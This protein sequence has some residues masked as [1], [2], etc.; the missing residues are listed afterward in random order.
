M[1]GSLG[2]IDSSIP[3]RA[4]QGVTPLQPFN[5]LAT[6]GQAMQLRALQNQNALFPGQQQIQGQTITSNDIANQKAA[7]AFT[8]QN[9]AGVNGFVTPLRALGQNATMDQV[10][11]ALAQAKAMGLNVDNHIASLHASDASGAGIQGWI[12]ANSSADLSPAERVLATTP[13]VHLQDTGS[14]FQTISKAPA[15]SATPSAIT[16]SGPF[17]KKD[18]GPEFNSMS[19][20][21]LNSPVDV[22]DSQRSMPDGTPNPNYGQKMSVPLREVL[23]RQGVS[24]PGSGG[25]VGNGRPVPDALLNPSRTAPQQAASGPVVTSLAPGTPQEMEGS[26][27]HAIAARDKANGYQQRIQPVEGALSA[28]AGADTGKA[29]EV[30]NNIRAN[31]QDLTPGFLQKMM[32][33]SLTDPEKRIKFEEANKYLTGM[34]IN[35]PGGARSDAGQA[36]AGA[37]SPSIHISNAAATLVARAVLAQHRLEQ[38]GTL[39]FNNTK[40]PAA[41]YDAYMN[42]WNTNA[43]PRAFVADKMTGQERTDLVKSRFG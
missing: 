31:V 38:A 14:G 16:T 19:E 25:G 5:P 1:S 40:Q 13:D 24:T 6:M 8:Q 26:A 23:R 34:A 29:S 9:N 2:G 18:T 10:T 4:G 20:T 11:S 39:A 28:L 41:N 43:D 17:I 42:Q 12:N 30:L 22:I 7:L 27:T 37:A 32:P 35:A 21:A 36:A 33:T 15:L 3:L